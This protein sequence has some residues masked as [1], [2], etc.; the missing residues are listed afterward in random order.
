MLFISSAENQALLVNLRSKAVVRTYSSSAASQYG[1]N[2][3]PLTKHV[4]LHQEKGCSSFFGF[5]TKQVLQRSLTSESLRSSVVTSCG[6]FMIGGGVNGNLFVWNTYTGQLVRVFAAHFR[7]INCLRC[8]SDNF[9][10]ITCSDDSTCKVWLL[11]SLTSLK[12]GVPNP[13]TV[14]TEH[15]LPI[16]SCAFL[17]ETKLAVTGSK[18]KCCKVFNAISGKEYFT[19]FV[20]KSITCV[21]GRDRTVVVGTED[22]FIYCINVDDKDNN[23]NRNLVINGNSFTES[24]SPVVFISFSTEDPSQLL[25]AFQNGSIR[26]YNAHNGA[27]RDEIFHTKNIIFSVCY[28]QDLS[29]TVYKEIKINKH[30]LDL[31]MSSYTVCSRARNLISTEFPVSKEEDINQLFSEL[32]ELNDL[33]CTLTLKLQ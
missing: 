9:I 28:T 25:V 16:P 13:L 21:I 10:V 32:K 19:L 24:P 14:F 18:D 12:I 29:E 30:P 27:P 26:S 2:F 7:S 8:S 33:K 4:V 17:S 3:L 22:G 1:I 5:H 15:T 31:S 23:Q 11:S 6:S 20:G